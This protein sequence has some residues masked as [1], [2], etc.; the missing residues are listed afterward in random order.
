MATDG[1]INTFTTKLVGTLQSLKVITWYDISKLAPTISR[2]EV[3]RRS[4]GR[5]EAVES[6]STNRLTE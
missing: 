2:E 5:F 6:T 4:F 1:R 3:V